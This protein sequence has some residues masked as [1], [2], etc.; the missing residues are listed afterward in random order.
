MPHSTK[1]I[2]QQQLTLLQ[3]ILHVFS[4][5]MKDVP[6]RR[7]FMLYFYLDKDDF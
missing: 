7:D 6:N 2:I 3:G 4:N 1:S 5:V